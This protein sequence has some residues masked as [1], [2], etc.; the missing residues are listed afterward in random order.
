MVERV[1]ATQIPPLKSAADIMMPLTNLKTIFEQLSINAASALLTTCNFRY[2]Y[3]YAS[4][5]GGE[6][7]LKI[8]WKKCFQPTLL[9]F[10]KYNSNRDPAPNP[11]TA[12]VSISARCQW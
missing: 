4:A 10:L 7:V 9:T 1:C 2:S 6:G 8:G 12:A 3:L 11:P 5:A